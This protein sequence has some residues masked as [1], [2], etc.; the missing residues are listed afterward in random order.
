MPSNI[1]PVVFANED[2]NRL[3]GVLHTPAT[4]L[5]PEIAIVLLSP[6]IKSRVAPHRLYVKLARRLCEA[7]FLVLRFDFYGLGDAEGELQ[8]T[9]VADVYASVA[10]GRYLHDTVAAM[11]WLQQEHHI[12][13]FVLAGLCGGAIT[14]L[15]AGA[16]DPRVISL[17][18]LGIPVTQYSEG[19]SRY[20]FLTE[21]E[22]DHFRRNYFKRAMNW[23][24]WVRLLTLRS[25]YKVM[26]KALLVP[27]KRIWQRHAPPA[28]AATAAPSD[29]A[30]NTNPHFSRAFFAMLGRSRKML[31][32]FGESDRLYWEFDEKFYRRSAS[33]LD[34][35]R[36]QFD[37]ELVKG[38]RHVFEAREQQEELFAKILDWLA[39]EYYP[40]SATKA[41]A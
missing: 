6:G 24:S 8:E 29:A 13:K 39:R 33:A 5:A 22:L 14:G 9:L 18:G 36:A 40:V 25:D 37:I 16:Q 7:G 4:N 19:A 11:N 35:Y 31:L 17:V 26:T 38:A 15:F 28:A 3:F 1:T 30:G 20:Q 32:V 21:Q 41:S 12:S 27:A 10:A 2:G 34:Q 23:K